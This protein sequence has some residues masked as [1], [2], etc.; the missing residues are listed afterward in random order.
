MVGI[1]NAGPGDM[2]A[3][4]VRQSD[5]IAGLFQGSIVRQKSSTELGWEGISVERLTVEPGEKSESVI[6]HHYV[7]LW[8][9]HSAFGER[10]DLRGKF[11][12]YSK[13]PGTVS[14]CVP[15]IRPAI[16]AYTKTE[17]IV[18]ALSQSFLAEIEDELGRRRVGPFHEQLGI[19]DVGLRQLVTLLA[20]EVDDGGASGKLYADSLAHA[21]GS[22]LIY[23][24]RAEQQPELPKLSALPR[25]LLQ[26]VIERMRVSFKANLNLTALAAE[27]GYSRAHFL[28]MFRTA[29]GQTPHRFLLDLRLESARQLIREQSS[30]L[31]EIAADCGFS[32]HA[33]FTKAFKRRFGVTPSMYRRES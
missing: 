27:T 29:T 13:H 12:P 8:D 30:R 9:M 6:D 2:K 19:D 21:L 17:A 26:R 11:A 16:R 32:S 31:I 22:R 28:R 25:H 4:E 5:A 18:C 23:L 1:P 15:G 3:N 14:T 24:G 7:I 10:A 33:Y 20:T